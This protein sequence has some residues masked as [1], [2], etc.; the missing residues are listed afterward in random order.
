MNSNSDNDVTANK[1][2]SVD[3][4]PE[5]VSC[6]TSEAVGYGNPPKQT[7]FKKGQSGNRKGRPKQ[8][9]Q[10]HALD[11]VRGY[12]DMKS[13][14]V[15]G[16]TRKMPAPIALR[17]VL[18]YRA[19]SGDIAAAKLWLANFKEL[20]AL[21]HPPPEMSPVQEFRNRVLTDEVLNRLPL[22]VLEMLATEARKED[23][24]FRASQRKRTS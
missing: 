16:R 17:E 24:R 12:W 22:Y 23:A 5:A 14:R 2:C 13:I 21:K 20:E 10:D 15:G 6:E 11:L 19:M 9:P 18:F 7:R 8:Y 1:T 3:A 4:E